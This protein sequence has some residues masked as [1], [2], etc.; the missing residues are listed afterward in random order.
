MDYLWWAYSPQK[1]YEA[2]FSMWDSSLSR[3]CGELTDLLDEMDCFSWNSS[4]C[5]SSPCLEVS[6]R[7]EE[8]TV[9]NPR[10]R[11]AAIFLPLLRVLRLL[12][13]QRGCEPAL[14][15]TRDLSIREFRELCSCLLHYLARLDRL[16]GMSVALLREEQLERE[17][18]QGCFG[19][20]ARELFD[21]LAPERRKLVVRYLRQQE[22][23][24]GRHLYFREAVK[25]IFPQA[26]LFFYDTDAIFLLYL[27]QRENQAD[28]DCLKLLRVLFFE[29]TARLQ[30]YW[31]Y[32]FGIIGRKPT[33][34]LNGMRLYAKRKEA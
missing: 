20:C 10:L 23:A 21:Q 27:P 9:I 26:G 17:L 8:R 12:L 2:D 33:M 6:L 4:P 28:G 19:T 16:S 1:F 31:E 24:K 29:A 11:F 5:H 7:R 14:G 3:P 15:E 25:A 30:V 18:R 22:E 34:R 32:P 13:E